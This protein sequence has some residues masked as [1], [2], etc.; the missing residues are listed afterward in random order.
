[1][2][3]LP[4]TSKWV[5][6]KDL[7]PRMVYRLEEFFKHPSIKN[8]IKI[9]SGARTYQQQAELYRRYKNGTGNLAANPDRKWGKG[10]KWVGSAHQ[11]QPALGN[12]SAAVDLRIV[13]NVSWSTVHKTALE[14]GLWRNIPSEN[15]HHVCYGYY[16]GKWQWIP[17]PAV[18]A[19]K[20]KSLSK[21][22]QVSIKTNVANLQTTP[23]TVRKGSRG[24]HVKLC[25]TELVEK[26]IKIC[27]NPKKSGIDSIAGAM[28]VRGIKLF[29]RKTGNLTVDGICGPNTW[30]ALL[31]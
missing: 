25:Q 4:V 29:Q 26:N 27:K 30:K 14:F 6:T 7:H 1:M 23:K 17:A 13:G 10:G 15:W 3:K 28:T 21:Q 20:D 24:T 5:N 9:V 8:K 18:D 31:K 22:E 19:K 12:Y 16:E 2:S 11:T